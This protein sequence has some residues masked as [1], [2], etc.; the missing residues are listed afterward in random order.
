MPAIAS[1]KAIQRADED[2]LMSTDLQNI[3]F[4]IIHQSRIHF[5]IILRVW[6][7]RWTNQFLPDFERNF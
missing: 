2:N 1:A 5:R 7:I 6:K 4:C 3:A